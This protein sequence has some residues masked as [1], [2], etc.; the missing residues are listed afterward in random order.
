MIS[1]NSWPFDS[2][3][4]VERRAMWGKSWFKTSFPY[5]LP[6]SA[7]LQSFISW[8]NH[9]EG[10]VSVFK[11]VIFTDKVG[12]DHWTCYPA[13]PTLWW[14]SQE[15]VQPQPSHLTARRRTSG[16]HS[17]SQRHVTLTPS[18]HWTLATRHSEA[19]R[20]HSQSV[21]Q[22]NTQPGNILDFNFSP[23]HFTK[24]NIL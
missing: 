9:E 2:T 18:S 6:L 3:S 10:V 7:G 16:G 14:C 23:F 22:S 19:A 13:G 24:L 15:Q 5:F 21:S 20:H 11:V 1:I 8:L 17:H 12:T 4:A